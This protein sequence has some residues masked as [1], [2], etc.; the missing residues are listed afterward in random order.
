MS[1]DFYDSAG[2][3]YAY[4][5]DRKTIYNFPG[6]PVAYIS[7]NSIYSFSGQHLGFFEQGQVWD[8][9]GASIL[10][11]PNA[12]GGPLKPVRQLKPLKGLKQLKPP[13]GLKHLKPL[14]QL[15]T[16]AW[17]TMTPEELFER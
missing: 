5:D 9:H 13:K 12:T 3:P 8:H 4:T 11:T 16:F 7:G 17:S 10:F 6:K 14:K 15:K 2:R 1:T